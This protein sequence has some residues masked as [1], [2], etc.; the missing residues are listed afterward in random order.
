MKSDKLKNDILNDMWYILIDDINI[1]D[2]MWYKSQ[3]DEA[4][5]KYQ[6]RILFLQR[7]A[8]AT[9]AAHA[10]FVRLLHPN[11]LHY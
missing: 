8:A 5:D 11:N 2:K 10:R 4:I 7:F 6:L 1:Y 3:R 9:L